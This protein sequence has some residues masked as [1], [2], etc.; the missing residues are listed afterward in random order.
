M[1]NGTRFEENEK[2]KKLKTVLLITIPSV[3]LVIAIVLV[4]VFVKPFSKDGPQKPTE[5]VEEQLETFKKDDYVDIDDPA[6][7]AI[8]IKVTKGAKKNTYDSN[9]IV[10]GNHNIKSYMVDN[11]KASATGIDVSDY[12]G[13]IDF[14]AVKNAGID[15]VMF[16]IG[17]RGYGDKGALFTDDRFDEYYTKAKEANLKVGAYFFSQSITLDEAIEEADFIVK[18]L[19]GRKLDYPIAYDWEH[20]EG[21]VA[22]TDDVSGEALTNMA[23]AFCNEIS[24]KGYIPIIYSN[25]FLMYRMYDLEALKDIDFWVADYG[26]APSM[27]YG[28]T[29]WQYSSDSVIPGI[30][31]TIDLN[32]C[33]KNY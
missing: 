10:T 22:R 16:R 24:E 14:N 30:N 7:G 6:L 1:A 9:N 21:D 31:D 4:L 17:G 28:F 13:D 12:Q 33:F 11:K 27:Y 19:N 3:I 23:Y 26:D 2:P 29:M 5:F 8:T 32:L 20:I 15:Y 25:T 18:T